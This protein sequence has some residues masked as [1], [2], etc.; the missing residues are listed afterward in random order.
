MAPANAA[1]DPGDIPAQGGRFGRPAEAAEITGLSI[2][3]IRRRVDDWRNGGR[4]DYAL[5]GGAAQG[6]RWVDLDDARA[7]AAQ[8]RGDLP[9]NRHHRGPV[10]AVRCHAPDCRTE[11][12]RHPSRLVALGIAEYLGWR[13]PRRG[14][15]DEVLRCPTHRDDP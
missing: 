7:L 2:Q 11:P 9:P 6:D 10:E 5:R 4:S 12:I 13:I 3:T 8:I 14:Q 15:G 1:A